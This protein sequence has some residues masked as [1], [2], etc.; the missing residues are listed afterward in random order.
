MARLR[1]S[2]L[3]GA[4]DA[5]IDDSE[6]TLSSLDFADLPVVASPDYL[7][8][9]LDPERAAGAPEVVY[10]TAHT[11]AATSVT[12]TRGRE[13]THGAPAGRSHA[14]GVTWH[15][16][17]TAGEFIGDVHALAHTDSANPIRLTAPVISVELD[18]DI[19]AITDGELNEVV[20]ILAQGSTGGEWT[21]HT[22]IVISWE[23]GS[24][25]T[26]TTTTG[27]YDVI[28][29]IRT[30]PGVAAYIGRVEVADATI[31]FA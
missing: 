6:T 18:D 3:S 7:P 11:S 31:A 20:L 24:P 28:R 8:L 14:S 4:L 15:H 22:G 21:S 29:L 17:P 13:Q 1:Y 23:A 25:P 30:Q 2:A 10:V 19:E 9:I 5:S 26:L 16:G 27:H 12:V